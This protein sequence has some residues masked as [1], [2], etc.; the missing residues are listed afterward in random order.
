MSDKNLL[1][2]GFGVYYDLQTNQRFEKTAAHDQALAEVKDGIAGLLER[3]FVK[4]GMLEI[5]KK[6]KSR[7]VKR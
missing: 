3:E 1:Y 7:G 4:Q 2:C 6:N 5:E